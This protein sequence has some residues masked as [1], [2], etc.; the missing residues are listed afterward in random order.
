MCLTE[1]SAGEARLIHYMKGW[2]EL[3][4][5]HIAN[6]AIAP[7]FA[8]SDPVTLKKGAETFFLLLEQADHRSMKVK[9][10]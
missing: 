4:D 3:M 10:C 1:H 2:A 9:T 8:N 6:P 7:R 5:I